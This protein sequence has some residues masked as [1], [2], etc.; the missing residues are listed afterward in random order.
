MKRIDFTNKE[1]VFNKL[2]DIFPIKPTP[3]VPV[4]IRGMDDEDIVHSFFSDK[5]WTNIAS[6][7]NLQDDSYALELGVSFLPEN[8]FSYYI[9]LYIYAAL[10]NK[11]E[12]WVFESDFIQHYLCPEYQSCEDF[13]SFILNFSDSQMYII[14]QFMSYESEVLGFGYASRA[15]QDFWD[16]YL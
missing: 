12:L 5:T 8:V 13:F 11:D 14:A 6:K 16:L 10:Y 2:I 15:C 3:L 1:M 7:L 4:D 9:P